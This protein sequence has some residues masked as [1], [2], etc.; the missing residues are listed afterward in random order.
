MGSRGRI[1]RQ[2]RGLRHF[3]L[4][5]RQAR[6]AGRR[7]QIMEEDI[8]GVCDETD[9]PR[10]SFGAARAVRKRRAGAHAP[11]VS[12]GRESGR[13][14]AAL[15]QACGYGVVAGSQRRRFGS[16]LGA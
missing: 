6:R 3:R 4:A 1:R 10:D 8:R 11:R 12:A 13:R 9:L 16:V 5:T 15:R 7:E 2:R 14:T